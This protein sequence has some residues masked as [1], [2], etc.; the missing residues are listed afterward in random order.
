MSSGSRQQILGIRVTTVEWK[1][2][3]L[4]PLW[5]YSL[6]GP[7]NYKAACKWECLPIPPWQVRFTTMGTNQQLCPSYIRGSCSLCRAL[8]PFL[9]H[10]LFVLTFTFS[11]EFSFS[12][13]THGVII[14][15]LSCI[16]GWQL[17]F[18]FYFN[19]IEPKIKK[20]RQKWKEKNYM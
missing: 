6:F 18:S 10:Q 1:G 9:Y 14:L 13:F 17:Y 5:P 8:T 2:Q 12:F 16:A 20:R 3:P 4:S 11:L 15:L 19:P 7:H